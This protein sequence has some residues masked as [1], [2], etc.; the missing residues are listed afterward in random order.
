MLST[1]WLSGLTGSR[2]IVKYGLAASSSGPPRSASAMA[3]M[4]VRSPSS[5]DVM[6]IGLVV[7]V[8][9]VRKL[10]RY[11]RCGSMSLGCAH[12]ITKSMFGSAS[13]S[14]AARATSAS[15]LGRCSP[16]SRS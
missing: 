10:S 8:T 6:T 16:V 3:H 13:Q 5:S 7:L 12:D 2:Y 14:R 11:E 4:T 15:A 9:I 1:G